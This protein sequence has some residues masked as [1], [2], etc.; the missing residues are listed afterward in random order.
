MPITPRMHAKGRITRPV[1]PKSIVRQP[2]PTPPA[3]PIASPPASPIVSPREL[4]RRESLFGHA[5]VSGANYNRA[6]IPMEP[7]V[8]RP[9]A[10]ATP[11]A[12]ATPVATPVDTPVATPAPV[13]T[14]NQYTT[15]RNP[16]QSYYPD[17]GSKHHAVT[18]SDVATELKESY[19][20]EE[21]VTSTSLDILALYLKG[22]KILHMES[23]TLCEKRLNTLMLPAIII[24]SLCAILNFALQNT[25]YGAVLISCFN[26]A[27]AFLMSLVSYLKLDSKAQAHQSSAYKYQKLESECEFNSGRVLFI[28]ESTDLANIVDDVH[29]RVLEIKESNQFI[30]PEQIRYRFHQ[31]YSTNVFTLVKAIQTQEIIYINDLKVIV[32]K[33]Q[34]IRGLKCR[35][36]EKLATINAN[37]DALYSQEKSMQLSRNTLI[38][39]YVE[40]EVHYRMQQTTPSPHT[41]QSAEMAKKLHDDIV[42][43]VDRNVISTIIDQDIKHIEEKM[44]SLEDDRFETQ[45][46]IHELV[47]QR[48]TLETDKVTALK[49]AITHREEYMQLNN[50]YDEDL[51]K[52]REK[53]LGK[54][55]LC[56][57]C[58][59]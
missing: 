27:N 42:K 43:Q 37:M 5:P 28:K 41:S 47:I 36:E 9:V 51:K 30:I 59:T 54:W 29:N 16:L 50:L 25:S 45:E 6:V 49:K 53:Q 40:Q 7:P 1:S 20:F 39:N 31:I 26:V 11:M 58:K 56:N 35:E 10:T 57:W 21:S 3:S 33:M 23:K 19:N 44:K 32:Q 8:I 14:S 4:P 18:F 15:F 22:Q 55:R 48:N 24:S 46:K 34:Y 2:T 12:T 52:D 13:T 17:N 38:D